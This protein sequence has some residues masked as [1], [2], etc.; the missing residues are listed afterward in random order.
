MAKDLLEKL[1]NN[2]KALRTDKKWTQ[3]ELAELAQIN[4]KEVSPIEAG[5]RNLT[6]ETFVKIAAALDVAPNDLLNFDYVDR[7][8]LSQLNAIFRYIELYQQLALDHGINDIFQDNGGKLLQVLIIT[9]LIDLPGREGNDAKDTLNNEYELKSVNTKLTKSFS[10]HHHMNPT[11]I[12]KYRLVD[13]VFAVYEG[14][15]LKEIY[16]LKPDDLQ[17]YYEKWETKWHDDGGKDINNPKIPLNYV[18]EHGAK[19]YE[20]DRDEFYFSDVLNHI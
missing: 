14:I 1:G 7:S 2:I 16:L 12:A 9:G 20:D 3:E 5:K 4:D 19:L 18:R 15:E 13:W 6:F 10:T 17:P 8:P 11:I